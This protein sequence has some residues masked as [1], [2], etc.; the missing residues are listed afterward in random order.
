MQGKE[1]GKCLRGWG[2]GQGFNGR[3]EDKGLI[4][5]DIHSKVTGGE[6]K[7]TFGK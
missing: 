7:G 3:A 5:G 1:E 2:A 6:R 4:E